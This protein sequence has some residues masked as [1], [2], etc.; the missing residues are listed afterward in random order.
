MRP[1]TNS[2]M[3]SMTVLAAD[4]V[5]LVEHFH[6]YEVWFGKTNPQTATDWGTADD[7][8][9]FQC[10]SG[11]AVYGADADDEA[12]VIG[13]DNTP[14]RAGMTLFDFHRILIID[15]SHGAPYMMRFAWGD[16]T[17]AQAIIDEQYTMIPVLTPNLPVAQSGGIVFEIM[18]PRI[19]AG[20]DQVWA[21]CKNA[22]DDATLDFLVGLHEYAV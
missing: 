10:I 20:I 2:A 16:T 19:R 21:Q 12:L 11:N 3:L 18:M 6:N 14:F 22:T 15:F 9:V 7:L 8:A 13:T 17:L 5:E 4:I 1:L